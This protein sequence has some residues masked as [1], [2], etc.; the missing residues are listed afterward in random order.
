MENTK[1][2]RWLASLVILGSL[3][4]LFLSLYDFPPQ[5]DPKPHRALGKAL[6]EHTAKLLGGGGRLIVIARDSSTFDIPAANIQME[7]FQQ[8][9]KRAGFAAAT[10]RLL[11][12]DPLRPVAVPPGDFFE[13]IR[14]ASETDVI[15]SFLGPP[16]LTGEQLARLGE[17]RPR[18]LAVCS[19]GIPN[20]ADLKKIFGERLLQ[21][22]II[23]R[24]NPPP[25]SPKEGTPQAWFDHFYQV[26]TPANLGDLSFNE[27]AGL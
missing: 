21:T 20:Q 27:P 9:L 17:K 14:K 23:S 5:P 2:K 25:G 15:V 13:I 7:S 10:T 16:T 6:A 4:L 1:V 18:I 26:I 11:K 19:G 24:K 8:T 22:A 3:V 12:V